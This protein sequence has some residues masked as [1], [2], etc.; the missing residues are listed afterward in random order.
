MMLLPPSF[1]LAVSVLRLLQPSRYQPARTSWIILE[2]TSTN[3]SRLEAAVLFLC[4]PAVVVSAG[5]TI[6]YRFWRGDASLREHAALG[7]KILRQHLP[8]GL[9]AT[10]TLLGAA[11]LALVVSHLVVG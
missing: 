2:W 6:V 8:I 11:I 9:L 7:L 3:I 1:L 10:A 5:L 4:L